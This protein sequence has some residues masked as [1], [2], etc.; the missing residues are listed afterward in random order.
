M[1]E[2]PL[3]ERAREVIAL[4]VFPYGRMTAENYA[5]R[6]GKQWATF[7]FGK[8]RYRNSALDQWVHNLHHILT[9]QARQGQRG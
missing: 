8:Y 9:Q 3:A 4:E 6:H 2:R 1:N 5:D 7:S